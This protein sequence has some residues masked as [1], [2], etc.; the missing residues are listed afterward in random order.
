MFIFSTLCLVYLWVDLDNQLDVVL[1]VA[2][3]VDTGA[4]AQS[5]ITGQCILRRYLS[6]K[7]LNSWS[8]PTE[9]KI[10]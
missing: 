4:H 3:W 6:F 10:L 8:V 7:I 9:V 5:K 2:L 1:C